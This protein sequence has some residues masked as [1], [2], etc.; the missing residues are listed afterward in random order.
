MTEVPIQVAVLLNSESVNEWQRRA[1]EV[2]FDDSDIQAEPS[3]L[4]VDSDPR[5]RSRLD[6]VRTHLSELSLWKVI[7]S[8]HLI[9][10][11]VTGPPWY[12]KR[13]AI[14]DIDAFDG[15]KKI[16]SRR[17]PREGLGIELSGEAVDH[18]EK[19]DIAIRFGFGI[20][21]GDALTAPKYGMLSYHH[22][23]LRQYRGRPAGFHEF[24]RGE[25]SV[26]V[27]VQR[28]NESLDG[29]DI[30]AFKEVDISDATSWPEVLSRLYGISDELLLSGVKNCVSGDLETDPKQGSLYTIPTNRETLLYLRQKLKRICRNIS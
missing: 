8:F 10:N 13:T 17:L 22:G 15:V 18:L 28:L 9:K 25:R 2:L 24:A 6:S 3:L 19:T 16:T 26:G 20:V 30:A 21:M 11:H 23:D 27:T 14:R 1:L 29:G 5:N 7:R 12:K 4:V